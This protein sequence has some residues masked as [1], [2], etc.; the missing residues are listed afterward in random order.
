[1]EIVSKESIRAKARDAYAAGLPRHAHGMNW[2]APALA[3]WLAEYDRLALEAEQL[4]A[5]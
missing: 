1:M 3:D 2:H 4:E 5:A